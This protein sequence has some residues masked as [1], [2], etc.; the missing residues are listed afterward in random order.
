[1]ADWNTDSVRETFVKFFEEKHAHTHVPSSSVLPHNDPTLLFVNAGMN[2]FKSV[3]LGSADPDSEL[4]RLKRA[5]NSQRCIRAGGKHNDLEDVGRDTYHHTMFEMLGSWSFG[6][7]FKKE[8]CAMA[9]E[10]LTEVY[11]MDPTRMYVT[12]F[13]GSEELG[14]PCDDE[15]RQIWLDLGIPASR[16]VAGN[17]KDNFWEM[18]ATGPCG[19]ASE[20]H[21][22][23]IGGRDASSLVNMDDE[24][25]IEIW[26]LV[27]ME[28]DRQ[29]D[30][31]LCKL[32]NRNIDTGMGLERLTSIL[33]NKS[34][35]YDTDAFQPI[36]ARIH[37]LVGGAAY[38]TDLAD[39]RSVAYRVVADHMR[40]LT[41]AIADGQ[42][43]DKAGK[44]YV[45]RRILRRAVHFASENLGAKPGFLSKLVPIV[46]ERL[47]PVFPELPSQQERVVRMVRYEEDLF[48]KTLTNGVKEFNKVIE[49][50]STL[51]KVP[52]F[53]P[54][55]KVAVLYDTHG[56][57]FDLTS[58]K[59]QALGYKVDKKAAKA[60][61]AEMQAQGAVGGKAAA[62]TLFAQLMN[63]VQDASLP[64]T[65]DSFKFNGQ[66]DIDANVVMMFDPTGNSVIDVAANCTDLWVLLDRTNFYACMGGQ[67]GDRGNL[68]LSSGKKI[69][70]LDTQATGGYVVHIC[71]IDADVPELQV[72]AKVTAQLNWD[73]RAPIMVNHTTTHLL[74]HA[75]YEV[76][77]S[78]VCQRGSFV[79]A[80]RF[81]FD[82]SSRAALEPE[83]LAD[84]EA[85]VQR[86]IDADVEVFSKEV[87]KEKALS[88]NG[89]RTLAGEDYTS[90]VR[91]VSVGNNVDHLLQNPSNEEWAKSSIEF[92]GG[93]HISRTG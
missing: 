43:P 64:A 42:D 31:S 84:L 4:G 65:D 18:G 15:T 71:K 62:K 68:I 24:S 26:N 16:L 48:H 66:E 28:F 81:R 59:A 36:F 35:N 34:S 37:E 41:V 38:T 76:V 3:F 85:H 22:D 10:L 44:G 21:Y 53:F 78:S 2:Q 1:M 70:V 80:P 89:L 58:L 40:T 60:C 5:A 82:F 39:P 83:Q 79:D 7:Y 74:N 93:T 49:D 52:E 50:L 29:S 17:A 14:I 13:E 91:V 33:V 20:I 88:I 92:C 72:G 77:G 32:P 86:V 12:Y 30:G 69:Q 8:A 46:V 47:T 27:F 45:L 6:D 73:L 23:R 54:A 87:A 19:T 90:M 57:P 75:L 25:V 55:D 56:F 61:L 11:K 51:D 67:V 63:A 9:W